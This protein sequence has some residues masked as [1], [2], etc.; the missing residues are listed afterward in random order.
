MPIRSAYP[1]D[2]PDLEAL[3][4]RAYAPV[5]DAM[6]P[7]YALNFCSAISK[8]VGQYGEKGTWFVA[9]SGGRLSGCVAFFAPRSI[10]HHLFHESWAHVQLLGVDPDYT[11]RGVGKDLMRHCMSAARSAGAS[12][13]AL[14][15]SALMGPARKLYESLGFVAERSTEPAFGHPA[16]LY[17]RSESQPSDDAAPGFSALECKR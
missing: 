16:F 17:I 14:Q 9:E 13:F 15:T 11:R 4:R 8:M 1:D 12:V 5:L 3:L 6:N 10:E 2:F 7:E